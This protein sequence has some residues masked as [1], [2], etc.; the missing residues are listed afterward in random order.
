[1]PSVALAKEGSPSLR[2]GGTEG[3]GA[4]RSAGCGPE[5]VGKFEKLDGTGPE[6]EAVRKAV[7]KEKTLVLKSGEA[8]E[9]EFKKSAPGKKVIHLATHGFFAGGKCKSATVDD[10]KQRHGLMMEKAQVT[11]FNPMVLSGVVFA[12]VNA[13]R[14]AIT[15]DDGIL[16]AE[17]V[18][19]MD[20]R[21]TELVVLSACETGL[22]EVKNGE[23]V[24]GLRRA[25]ALAGAKS[26]VM[27]LW[28]VPDDETKELM[29]EFYVQLAKDP[30]LAKPAALRNAQLKLIAAKRKKEG[31]AHP[32]LWAGFIAAG[33]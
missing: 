13:K 11:G 5:S 1:L 6:V 24:M 32:W 22:G 31:E 27:S 19:G 18:A 3:W 9:D 25:F 33:R 12:G 23:G 15:G 14:G 26:L 28:K 20:M 17:E 29:T 4:S 16:T 21:G 7:G 2:R 30:T 8:T 10:G